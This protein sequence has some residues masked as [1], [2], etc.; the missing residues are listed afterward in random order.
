LPF[1]KNLY[2]NYID[3]IG[4]TEIIKWKNF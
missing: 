2:D 3:N 4:D 1:A